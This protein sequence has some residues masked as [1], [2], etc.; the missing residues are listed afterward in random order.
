M[1]GSEATLSSS[2]QENTTKEPQGN[3]EAALART[4]TRSAALYF[5]RPVRLFRPSKVS[6]WHSLRGLATEHGFSLSPQYMHNLIRTQGF[7]VIPKHF[8]PPMLVNAILGTILWGTYAEVFTLVEPHVGHHPILCA[9]LA[10]SVAGGVQALLAAPAENVRILLEGGSGGSSWSKAW[11]E[12]F[13][14]TRSKSIS[15]RNDIEDI[16]QLRAWMKD[17]GNMAGRGWKGWGWGFGKDIC[18]FATFFS[19]FEV[20]RHVALQA[21]DI[22][23]RRIDL[24][25]QKSSGGQRYLPRIIHGLTLVSGGVLAGLAYEAVC[26]PWDVARRTVQVE[27]ITTIPQH[28]FS[29][30]QLIVQKARDDGILSFF[31]SHHGT[32]DDFPLQSGFKRRLVGVLRTLGRVGPWGAGF[33]VWEAYRPGLSC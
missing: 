32:R 11:K 20:T 19:V 22:S 5:S 1:G 24:L 13:Q 25:E 2:V 14:G 17:V 18:G 23:Q 28:R 9:G 29:V 27:R 33:L 16:R 10:G 7:I 31:R 30:V 8:I 12:V 15:R 6:G 4:L 21:K 3:L 26:R